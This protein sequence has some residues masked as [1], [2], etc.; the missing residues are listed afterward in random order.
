MGNKKW[1]SI[2]YM[3]GN[4]QPK[5]NTEIKYVEIQMASQ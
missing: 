2:G 5:I 1:I 3:M 4:S